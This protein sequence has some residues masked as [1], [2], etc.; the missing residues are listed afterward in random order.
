MKKIRTWW[1]FSGIFLIVTAILHTLVA[2]ALGIKAFLEWYRRGAFNSIFADIANSLEF[3]FFILGIP[4]LF[5]GFT[6]HYYIKKTQ[7]SPPLFLGYCF[8][9]FGIIGA[10]LAPGSGLFLFILQ[11]LIIVIAQRS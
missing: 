5:F 9:F 3:W 4:L 10:I 2:M 7:K 1:K 8:L 6:L 11:G